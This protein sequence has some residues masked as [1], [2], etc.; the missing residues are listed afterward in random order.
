M[1]KHWILETVYPWGN[2]T[3]AEVIGIDELRDGSIRYIVRFTDHC[4]ADYGWHKI[5]IF[6]KG[7]QV[8]VKEEYLHAEP[9]HW[10]D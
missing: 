8:S 10:F 2:S 6:E 1:K 5:L 9:Q 3:P 4:L 7:D